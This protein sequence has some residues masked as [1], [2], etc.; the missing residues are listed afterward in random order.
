MSRTVTDSLPLAGGISLKAR[1]RRAERLSKLKAFALV[2]PLFLYV[3]VVFVIPIVLMMYRSVDNPEVLQ[4][5]P[6]TAQAIRAWDGQGL[7]AE[8]V[9]AALVQDLRE[10]RRDGKLGAPARRLNYEV[11]GFRNLLVNS[12]GKLKDDLQPPYKEALIALDKRWG[13]PLY[14]RTLY[15]N[16]APLTGYY[17]LAALDFKRDADGRIVRAESGES[18][19]VEIYGRTLWISTMV[20]LIALLLGYPLAYVLSILPAHRAN[21]LLIMVLL[22]FW[23]S[24]LVR[25]ASWIVLLQNGGL[26]N[27][28]LLRLGLIQEPIQLVFNR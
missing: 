2:L 18:A 26:I 11:T 16:S 15:R 14:W 24:L 23:T 22:P 21:L 1:L 6:R 13:E 5:L 25:T 28:A 4:N 20:T 19:F 17:L 3:L 10:G 12:A 27:S 8:P 7:P 9:Y